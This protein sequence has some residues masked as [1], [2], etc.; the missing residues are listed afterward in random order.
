[1]ALY[2]TA[3]VALRLKS[4]PRALNGEFVEVFLC[5]KARIQLVTEGTNRAE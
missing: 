3:H 5:M 1:M 4:P 2:A